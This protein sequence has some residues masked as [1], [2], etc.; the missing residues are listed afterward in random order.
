[1]NYI[2]RLGVGAYVALASIILEIIGLIIYSVNSTTGQ[3][4]GGSV[5]AAVVIF[6]IL[7]IICILGAV[8]FDDK[9]NHYISSY[10]KYLQEP[11]ITIRNDR[12]VIPV[13][14]EYKSNVKEQI[15][16]RMC[17]ANTY[18]KDYI[19]MSVCMVLLSN[20]I[21][22]QNHLRFVSEREYVSEDLVFDF[23]YYPL[24]KSVCISDDADYY[25]CD[26]GTWKY[27]GGCSMKGCKGTTLTFKDRT[28]SGGLCGNNDV[29]GS[30]TLEP[31]KHGEHR[32]GQYSASA[33]GGWSCGRDTVYYNYDCTCNNGELK[34][35]NTFDRCDND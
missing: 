30:I 33:S 8:F 4:A 15:L 32:S 3:M 9:L 26:N 11:V 22:K 5:S 34:C 19:E 7:P 21:I 29:Y 1:M 2:K 24:S 6:S 23:E 13:K 28:C 17:G 25:Y 31:F 16:P 18:G 12:F 35:S 10:S 20:E 27:S 14:E